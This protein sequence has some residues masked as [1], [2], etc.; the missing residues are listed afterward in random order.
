[1]SNGGPDEGTLAGALGSLPHGD[2]FRFVDDLTQLERGIRGEGV[3]RIKGDEDFLRGH[4]PGRPMMPAVIMIEAL[5]QLGGIVAQSDPAR[6]ALD[7]LRLTAMKRVRIFDAAVPGETLQLQAA[8]SGRLG[9]LIEIEGGIRC[10]ERV[11]VEAQITL[12]GRLPEEP[13]PRGS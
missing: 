8:V 6:P 11:L 9:N 1:M 13:S 5:A 3:Y 7:D 10:G 2:G 12:S 4:F